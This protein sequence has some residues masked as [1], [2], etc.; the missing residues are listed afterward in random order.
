MSELDDRLK[1]I[2]CIVSDVDGVLT[3][4]SIA[5]DSLG[6]PFRSVHARDVTA[7][8]LWRIA[9]GVSAIVSGLGSR[10]IEAVAATWGCAECHLWVRDKGRVCREMAERL[11][12]PM[13]AL[14]FLG[15]DIIDLGAMRCVGLS[16]AVAD[17]LPEVKN[18]AHLVTE[19]PGGRGPLREVVHRILAAQGRL[20]AVVAAYCGRKDGPQ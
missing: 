18:E 5:Y 4:G 8:T 17:A 20:D 14:A 1:K 19:A 15:D 11:Q 3:D 13:E 7:L 16:V 6:R 9:G 12:L 10:S 2:Q